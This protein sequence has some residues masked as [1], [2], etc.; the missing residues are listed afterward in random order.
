M[1]GEILFGCGM[2]VLLALSVLYMLGRARRSFI[3]KL[4]EGQIVRYTQRENIGRI[5]D[6][7]LYN[8]QVT[9]LRTNISHKV[10]KTDIMPL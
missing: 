1:I 5:T 9:D 8:C 6:V 4:H 3:E 7:W 2:L 10:K